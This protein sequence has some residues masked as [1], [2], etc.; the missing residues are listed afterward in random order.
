[1]A[2]TSLFQH[3]IRALQIAHCKNLEAEGHPVSCRQRVNWT[4]RRFIKAASRAGGAAVATAPLSHLEKALSQSS[5]S[6]PR[7]AIVGGGM[8]GL[9]AAYQ[10]RK[11]G[12]SA[13][14]YEG[15]RRLGGRILSVVGAV[16]KELVTDLGGS[17]INRN[18]NDMLGLLK[19][20][21]LQSFNRVQDS[22][23]FPVPEIGY[24]FDGRFRSEAEVAEKLRPL[25]LQLAQDAERL[26][27]D[28]AHFSRVLDQ[29]SVTEYLNKNAQA[30]SDP[31][32]RS[33]VEN[34]IRTEFGAEPAESSALTLIFILPSVN[35]KQVEILGSS[36]ESFCVQGGSGKVIER[37]AA[38]L[39]GQIQTRMRLTQL[40]A[41]DRDF[42]LTFNG[43][44][45]I[46]ADFVIIAIPF[47]VLR[48]IDLQVR[49]P[50]QLKQLIREA[51]LGLNE[52][53][54]AGFNQKV[55]R[56]DKGFVTD[57]WTDLGFSEAWD[58]TQRQIDRPDGALTFFLGGNEVESTR[59]L[60]AEAL[61]TQFIERLN[62]H[63]PGLQPASNDQFLRTQWANNPFSRG[64]YSRLKP[65]QITLFRN[66]SYFESDKPE[67][68]QNVNVGNLIFA[69]EHLSGEFAGYMNGA[70]QT[71]RLA[72]EV[73]LHKLKS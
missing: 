28:F 30:I 39:P 53:V 11:A 62:Q 7:I 32:I 1:M 51:D 23:R 52:K 48:T 24:C 13:T 68:R 3:F 33:L 41:R 26:D 15:S 63:L 61:G 35:D 22:Q 49:L 14:V 27:Q 60:K 72:A 19:E 47:T 65:G 6:E 42:R 5:F 57:V 55:W 18:H 38:A 20:F 31:F 50:E 71:G 44:R 59:H 25:A 40:Q 2:H 46:E 17:F 56:Q 29:L 69:G 34:T 67:Q 16:G 12:L 54:F 4:R 8:A 66:F 10:L 43:N 58:E 64:A 9:N 36:D 73:I 21:D 70:A 37:L 45:S